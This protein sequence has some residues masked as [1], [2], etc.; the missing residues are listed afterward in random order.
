MA[1]VLI[2]I[3]LSKFT[4]FTVPSDITA[5]ESTW[6]G[7]QCDSSETWN[8]KSCSGMSAQITQQMQINAGPAHKENAHLSLRGLL[9]LS[10]ESEKIS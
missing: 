5:V 8:H 6:S 7:I 4:D 2:T 1:R 9:E 10:S 3:F